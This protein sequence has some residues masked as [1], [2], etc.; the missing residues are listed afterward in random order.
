MNNN[1]FLLLVCKK[2]AGEATDAELK[3]LDSLLSS[4]A[5]LALQYKLQ[6]QFWEQHD[7][8]NQQVVEDGLQKLL[9][10]LDLPTA[11]VVNIEPVIKRSFFSKYRFGIA[12]A[13]AVAAIVL[14]AVFSTQRSKQNSSSIDLASLEKKQNSKGIKSTIQLADGSKV[15]LNA[16]SKIQ[17]PE[18]FEGNTREVYLNGE[19]F[20]EVARNPQKPFIIHLANG[21]VRV[22]G[23]SFN[24]RAY[25]NER[26]VETS[27]TTGKVAFIPKY[28]NDQKKADTV[29]LTP[30]N[31]A[32]YLFNA[33]KID[34]LPTLAINDKA[35]TEGKMIFKAMRLQ[36]IATELERN[37][38]KKVLFL[39]DE[40]KDYILTGSFQNNTLEEVM[41]YFSLSKSKKIYY[42]ITNNELLIAA[43]EAEL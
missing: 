28:K 7:T 18:A 27:V 5:D 37:F 40:A 25:D 13:A 15:W 31:K 29:F 8:P 2:L 24:I 30:N 11:N 33:E 26:V 6:Q 21:T 32:R 14:I 9:Q 20:F 10:R 42:K 17:Y 35:W 38:G 12:A 43:K 36:D 4:D 3:E 23:T 19:A 39:D 16:D 41:Y 34:V 1:D 22:L